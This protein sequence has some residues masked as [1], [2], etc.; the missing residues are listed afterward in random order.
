MSDG[1]QNTRLLAIESN[2]RFGQLTFWLLLALYDGPKDTTVARWFIEESTAFAL[3]YNQV[4]VYRALRR[5][6]KQGLVKV[7]NYKQENLPDAKIYSLTEY[8]REM[9]QWFLRRNQ[10][11]LIP[12]EHIQNM[13]IKILEAGNKYNE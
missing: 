12:E 2:Y 11:A 7:R 5:L 4:S 1:S 9:L 6:H 8:G 3:Q 13:I 10:T